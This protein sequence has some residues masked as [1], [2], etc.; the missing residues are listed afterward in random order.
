MAAIRSALWALII[1]L[2]AQPAQAEQYR[3]VSAFAA[4]HP[5]YPCAALLATTD[6]AK[7]PAVSVLFGTF[8]Y[9]LSC[10][11][12]FA[13]RYRDKPHLIQIHFSNEVCRRNGNCIDEFFQGLSVNAYN[14]KL[15]AMDGDTQVAISLR[16]FF[17]VSSVLSLANENTQVVLGAGLEDNYSSAAFENLA[18]QLAKTWPWHLSRNRHTGGRSLKGV[19]AEEFHS[20]KGKPGSILC[21]ANEDGNYGQSVKDSQAFFRRYARCA[22]V[23]AWREEHQGRSE[24]GKRIP[25]KD[26]EFTYTAKDV[27][28]LRK[29]IK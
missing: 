17:I 22:A 23:F 1:L 12:R 11:A 28:E 19:I 26:R 14:K 5:G 10:L 4:M 6:A 21:I 24:G 9:D 7:Q 8:G 29:V 3:G 2:S 18:R 20:A 25:P 13:E 27:V 15:E 16:T